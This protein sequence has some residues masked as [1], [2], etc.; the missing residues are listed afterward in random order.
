MIVAIVSDVHT[1]WRAWSAVQADLV[2]EGA[3][4][5]WS[6]GD[7][8]GYGRGDDPRDLM[9]ALESTEQGRAL[10]DKPNASCVVGNH[11][12]AILQSDV[13]WSRLKERFAF[14]KEARG[15]INNQRRLLHGSEQWREGIENWLQSIPHVLSP[16]CGVYL[17]HGAFTMDSLE[18]APHWYSYDDFLTMRS[19]SLP[20]LKH[21]GQYEAIR[22][23]ID[24]G[25]RDDPLARACDG[26]SPPIL[27]ATGHSHIQGAWQRGGSVPG[28][29]AWRRIDDSQVP[30]PVVDRAKST[31]G[32]VT[33]DVPFRATEV[34]P[35]WVNP[36]SVGRPRMENS[37]PLAREWRW[38]MYCLLRCDGKNDTLRFRWLPYIDDRNR[39][40]Q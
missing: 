19:A 20:V 16:R 34:C 7:W 13:D 36:G 39:G 22:A 10:L 12:L 14:R 21:E 9:R 23:W 33:W 35:V 38:A 1:N 8:L 30:G 29:L 32:A 26:W 17:S 11:D 27:L 15:A 24:K 6:L 18:R 5:I 37:S 3:D 25:K 40:L 4:C 2:A 31:R 28:Q